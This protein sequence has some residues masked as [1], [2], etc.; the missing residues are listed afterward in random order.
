MNQESQN[1]STPHDAAYKRFFS[2][3]EM[4][5]SLLRD[6][7][8]AAFV[9]EL[10]FSTLELL[11]TE[12]IGEHMQR[13]LC[14]V[15]WRV[16][17]K[18][19]LPCYV[20]LLLEFQSRPDTFMALRVFE[21]VALLLNKL[22]HARDH[23]VQQ[24]GLPFVFPFV[25]YNGTAAWHA[26]QDIAELFA[27]MPESLRA[28][29]PH[30]RYMLLQERNISAG[31][32]EGKGI[33][34]EL[35]RIEGVRDPKNL[36]AALTQAMARLA[37]PRYHRIRTIFTDWLKTA[38]FKRFKFTGE[39]S[40]LHT[41]LETRTMIEETLALWEQKFIQTGIE[42]GRAEGRQQGRAE[43][44]QKG[45]AEGRQQGRAEGIQKG[46]A[47][48]R[49]QGRA[50]GIQQGRAEGQ[51]LGEMK[52]AQ[53]LVLGAL[54]ERFGAASSSMTQRIMSLTDTQ[55]LYRLV[56]DAWKTPS[57][58]EFAKNLPNT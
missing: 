49:Q 25:L 10:D 34:A 19:G 58:G 29:M 45:R 33:A 41:T 42:Q 57:L 17:Y 50:E 48:G 2:E 6:F 27:P 28:F 32:L 38:I 3:P 12:Y 31:E 43:G 22:A 47:E 35:F 56:G 30:L 54:H 23:E 26:A 15:I 1:T 51:M 11:P 24:H 14:D 55:V 53:Q 8:H 39:L 40:Q 16:R 37:Q 20:V 44:I 46:R 21:Y 7:V 5:I 52:M 18:N 9:Q 13:R 4:V 36:P